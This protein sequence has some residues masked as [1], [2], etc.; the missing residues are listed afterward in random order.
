MIACTQLSVLRA[1]PRGQM[2]K[3]HISTIWEGLLDQINPPVV[4]SQNRYKSSIGVLVKLEGPQKI[5]AQYLYG[6]G[7]DRIQVP[8]VFSHT[9][10]HSRFRNHSLLYAASPTRVI[11]IPLLS[12]GSRA[13]I[14]H[15][16]I[17]A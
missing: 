16:G 2:D 10:N 4:D 15:T 14:V 1:G 6:W 12:N 8:W 17:C 3:Y 5:S 9:T 13:S 11:Y 7:L